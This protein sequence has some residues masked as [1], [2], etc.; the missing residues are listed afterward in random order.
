MLLVTTVTPSCPAENAFPTVSMVEK[1]C[2]YLYFKSGHELHLVVFYL[3][4]DSVAVSSIIKRLLTLFNDYQRA[5]VILQ[6]FT[7]AVTL[8]R[9]PSPLLPSV[10]SSLPCFPLLQKAPPVIREEPPAP[11]A[12]AAARYRCKL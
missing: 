11:A 12:P 1:N 3:S 2:T 6:V 10:T 7:L 5:V 9:L 4:Y 8:P